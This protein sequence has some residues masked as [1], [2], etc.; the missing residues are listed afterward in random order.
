MATG[1]TGCAL[2]GGFCGTACL[3]GAV[4]ALAGCGCWAGVAVRLGMGPC[5]EAFALFEN[6]FPAGFCAGLGAALFGAGA[7]GA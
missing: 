3:V 2:P 4:A 6:T 1:F 5:C 7:A